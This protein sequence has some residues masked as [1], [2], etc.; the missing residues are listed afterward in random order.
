MLSTRRGADDGVT[1]RTYHEG[2]EHDLS[3]TPRALD[4]AQV[5]IREGWAK[6]V[7]PPAPVPV[8]VER[9][10]LLAEYVA[11]GYQAA[12]YEAFIAEHTAAAKAAGRRVEV[13]ELTAA[14]KAEDEAQKAK[15]LAGE[16]ALGKVDEKKAPDA[17]PPA[18][19]D[20]RPNRRK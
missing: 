10:P 8:P 18:K 13:R 6:E 11:A 4:L 14:E 15:A 7:K 1:L 19:P 17:P 9:L 20:Q 5:F 2:T 3:A 12:T 16:D